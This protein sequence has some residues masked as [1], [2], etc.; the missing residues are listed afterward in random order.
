[1]RIKTT[2]TNCVLLLG[3]LALCSCNTPVAL[4]PKL[5]LKPPE[6]SISKPDLMENIKENTFTIEGTAKDQQEVVKLFVTVERTNSQGTAWK[7]EYRAERSGKKQGD[8]DI[9]KWGKGEKELVEWSV[10]VPMDGAEEGEYLITAGAENNVKKKSVL[11]QLRV[12]KDTQPPKVKVFTPVLETK[13]AVLE[14]YK[15][16]DL[17]VLDKLHNQKIKVQY[18]IQDDFSI[19]SLVFQLADANGKIYYN[20]DKIPVENLSWSGTLVIPA[21]EIFDEDGKEIKNGPVFM[22]LIS[23]A[24]DEAGNGPEKPP[25]SHGWLVWWPEA[26]KPWTEGAGNESG[27]EP[28]TV[29]PGADVMGQAYDDDGVQ[30]VSWK[31]YEWDNNLNKRGD[32]ITEGESKNKP[33][34]EGADPAKFFAWSFPAPPHNGEYQI[35][36]DCKDINDPPVSGDPVERYFY[37]MDTDAPGIEITDPDPNE[38]LFGG[39][40]GNFPITGEASDGV[41]PQKVTVV[42]IN[43]NPPLPQTSSASRVSYQSADYDGWNITTNED[44]YGNR[45]WNITLDA[46]VPKPTGNGNTRMIRSFEK[47]LNLFDDLNIGRSEYDKSPLAVQ[48]FIFRV[49]GDSGRAVTRVHSVRGDVT[50]PEEVNITMIA[51]KRGA[52]PEQT[53]TIT[54]GELNGTINV[55]EV[56]DVI[57]VSG[58]WRD[59]SFV[60]HWDWDRDKMGDITVTWNSVHLIAPKTDMGATTW[61]ASFIMPPEQTTK[62]GAFISARLEDLGGNATESSIS[63]KIET[64]TPLLQNLGGSPSNTYVAGD[65]IEIKLNLRE[66][67]TVQGSGLTLTLKDKTTS[68]WSKT[69]SY[70]GLTNG[71]RTLSFTYTVTDGDAVTDAL[72]IA[73]INLNGATLKKPDNPAIDFTARLYLSDNNLDYYTEI[74]IDTSRPVFQSAAFNSTTARLSLEFNKEIYKGTGNITIIQQGTFLAPAVLTKAE[75][76]RYGGSAVLGAYYTVGTNGTN[77]SGNADL[78][79]KYILNF[80]HNADDAPVKTA[81]T[82]RADRVVVPVD[83][84]AVSRSGAGNRFLYVDLSA[85]YGYVLLV[86]GV[87]Y[88]VTFQQ[89]LVQDSNGN[90]VATL[91][92]TTNN[93]FTNPGVNK[94]FI[95]VEKIRAPV[96][97]SGN[98]VG[99]DQR[100]NA[101][102]KIDCQTPDVA[103]TYSRAD[104]TRTIQT[105][106]G[107]NINFP[108]QR[109]VPNMPGNPGTP[110]A[111]S[112]GVGNAIDLL[113][114]PNNTNGYLCAIRAR[115]A[116]DSATD[117]YEVAA[118]SVI[119]FNSPPVFPSVTSYPNETARLWLRGGDSLSGEN[120]TPGFPLAW[121]EQDANGIQLLTQTGNYWDWVSWQVTTTAYFHFL[122]GTVSTTTTTLT[123]AGEIARGPIRWCWSRNAWSFQQVQFPLYPGGSLEFEQTTTVNGQPG[124]N[125]GWP[126]YTGKRVP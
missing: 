40:N 71:A 121:S 77:S 31:I 9:K 70:A 14:G 20:K 109:P 72:Q 90:K 69:A 4:G 24:A 95:R 43:P 45:L 80:V 122:A 125:Y 106:L 19:S 84:S 81:L 22:Q 61:K 100:Y 102:F 1:M 85:V 108:Q 116:A 44:A 119:R 78:T 117:A 36:I 93:T 56:G 11:V 27:A 6:V 65:V 124:G 101:Q 35:V 89:G 55:L 99:V 62:A 47:E 28:L 112:N 32:F 12:V 16:Q 23:I 107:G 13:R 110:Y 52:A 8:W 87:Q 60:D 67:V 29:Y 115:A 15:L 39:K 92:G 63:V 103:I 64:G 53:Y 126:D 111:R 123:A 17:A 98:T 58:T 73:G 42:W 30:S 88:A 66:A 34:V 41:M 21:K 5:N 120:L 54:N 57:T 37:V 79:E 83:S 76:E 33:L 49:E 68:T 86:K 2:I 46:A 94:P 59:D 38:S 97:G 113:T 51:V 7:R 96:I 3:L 50:P 74:K 114:S 75:Y 91:T 104:N 18:E 25:Y 10:K 118:R 82:G 48:T 105:S 26:D